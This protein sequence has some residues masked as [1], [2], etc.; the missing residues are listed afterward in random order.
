MAALTPDLL[1]KLAATVR[2]IGPLR[3]DVQRLLKLAKVQD[4]VLQKLEDGQ[5]DPSE[6]RS[7]TVRLLQ[8]D[9]FELQKV[10]YDQ[11]FMKSS[12]NGFGSPVKTGPLDTMEKSAR[13]WAV[14][15][16]EEI[17]PVTE[18]L[19]EFR[20]ETTGIPSPVPQVP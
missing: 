15:D 18:L 10:A 5:L 9:D 4:H 16:G 6:A 8:C 14:V 17:D 12:Y 19:Y 20:E 13:G 1:E 7:E 3:D 11:G 2:H